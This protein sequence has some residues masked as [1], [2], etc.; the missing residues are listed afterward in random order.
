MSEEELETLF[1]Q[2]MKL[3]RLTV[4]KVFPK[5]KYTAKRKGLE[6]E[7]MY[8]YAYTGLWKACISYNPDK[9]TSFRTHA[10]NHIRWHLIEKAKRE[11]NPMKY[12]ANKDIK[13]ED[14]PRISSMEK[15]ITSMEGLVTLHDVTPSSV[16]VEG[17][18]IDELFIQ[19]LLNS[20]TE[21]ELKIIWL[22][23]EKELTYKEIGEKYYNGQTGENT[24][25]K[26]R[27]LKS[28]MKRHLKDSALA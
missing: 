15:Q 1:K 24:R 6:L 21:E 27:N 19:E 9:G 3:A 13:F 5:P 22:R 20:A 28:Q 2:H 7:D 10:I 11:G 8:Q 16:V 18:A 17:S 26:L 14:M 4:H 12:D 23:V 25:A